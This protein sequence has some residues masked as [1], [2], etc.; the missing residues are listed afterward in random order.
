MIFFC[1][2]FTLF[3]SCFCKL[4]FLIKKKKKTNPTKTRDAS[5]SCRYS[6][7]FNKH[8]GAW[9]GYRRKF[10]AHP[11]GNNSRRNEWETEFSLSASNLLSLSLLQ[12]GQVGSEQP[13]GSGPGGRASSAPGSSGSFLGQGFSTVRGAGS[14]TGQLPNCVKRGFCGV[15]G[16]WGG[17]SPDLCHPT[18]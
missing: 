6:I 5:G 16:P 13:H 14:A 2:S 17:L 18:R 10:R 8:L 15:W 4:K 1:K 9:G 12:A 3:T 7:N 11:R